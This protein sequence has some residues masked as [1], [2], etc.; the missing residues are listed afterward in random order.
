[1]N[2][3]TAGEVFHFREMVS[4][5]PYQITSRRLSFGDLKI[6][7]A[8]APKWVLYAM[9]EEETISRETSPRSKIIHVLEGNLFMLVA[10]RPCSLAAGATVMV[11]ADTWHEFAA[12]SKCKFLQITI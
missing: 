12:H 1:M 3:I 7:P 9:D 6:D 5:K 4:V 10:D 2:P 8:A 11:Q